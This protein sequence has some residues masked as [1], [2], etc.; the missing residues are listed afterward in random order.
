MSLAIRVARESDFPQLIALFQEFAHFQKTPERMTNSVAQMQQEK[1]FFQ[2]FVAVDDQGTI[3]GYATW[4]FTYHTWVGK[5]LYMDDLYV[6]Q[7]H[8]GQ[9]LGQQLLQRVIQ[10]AK[11]TACNRMRWLVSDWNTNAQQFYKK[12]G[13]SLDHTEMHCEFVLT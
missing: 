12:M 11:E 10:Q 2:G 4:F 7:A 5:C 1:E 13:A 3:V 9:G 6:N 8:R